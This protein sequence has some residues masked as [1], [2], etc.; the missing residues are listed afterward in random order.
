MAL[1]YGIWD[2]V[3]RHVGGD[4]SADTLAAIATDIA[5]L[6][7]SVEHSVAGF[8]DM[9]A[10]KPPNSGGGADVQDL[11][12]LFSAN[13]GA[14]TRQMRAP[15]NYTTNNLHCAIA[16]GITTEDLGD[17]VATGNPFGGG[18]FSGWWRTAVGLQNE[19]FILVAATEE[20]LHVSVD[21]D[22]VSQVYSTQAGAII[23][24]YS[25]RFAEANG[26]GYGMI[27]GSAKND[28]WLGSTFGGS[29]WLTHGTTNG[30][31]HMGMFEPGESGWLTLNRWAALAHA[32]SATKRNPAGEV[33]G[34]SIQVALFGDTTNTPIGKLR[35]I[36]YWQ[37][38]H[39]GDV[40]MDDPVGTPSSPSDSSNWEEGVLLI[41]YQSNA[42]G[43]CVALPLKDLRI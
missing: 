38:G 20:L 16:K 40:R 23:N 31:A 22:G 42:E 33:V 12:V 11:R 39:H 8:T 30:H 28:T 25:N 19:R 34:N 7:W 41:G 24:T 15:D 2:H 4:T 14:L 9:I 21:N 13:N 6:G 26:R 37:D 29:S 10:C 27:T 35:S 5:A 18:V 32:P 3:D 36:Y 43:D 1:P 17:G